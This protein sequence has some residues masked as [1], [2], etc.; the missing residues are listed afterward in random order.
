MTTNIAKHTQAEQKQRAIKRLAQI[1]RDHW[2][3]GRVGS[4]RIFEH[5]VPGWEFGSGDPFAR[6][7][8]C[9]IEFS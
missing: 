6:L 4:T 5:V 2:E 8:S 7:T 1:F 3:E 9:G